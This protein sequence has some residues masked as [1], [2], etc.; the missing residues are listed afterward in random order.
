MQGHS[1]LCFL[2]ISEAVLLRSLTVINRTT[3]REKEEFKR[4]TCICSKKKEE[5]KRERHA[6]KILTLLTI[7]Q[8]VFSLSLARFL[9]FGDLLILF[10]I[11]EYR[12]MIHTFTN[13]IQFQNFFF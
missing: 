6:W 8:V 12:D 7:M 1:P 13:F 3:G 5:K 9:I 4:K 10:Y 2:K 11:F